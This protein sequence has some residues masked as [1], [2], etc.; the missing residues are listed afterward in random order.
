MAG[1]YSVYPSAGGGGG[2]LS[3]VSFSIGVLDGQAATPQGAS[4]SSNSIFMQS[5]TA[6][7]PGLVSSAAQ[8]FTGVKTFNNGLVSNGSVSMSSN[9]ISNLA[10]PTTAQEAATK[11]YVDTSLSAFQPLEAVALASTINYPGV[12]VANVL[13]ITAT[14]AISIDGSTPNA[15]D[16]VLL[17][18]QT[19]QAQNGVYVVTGVGSVGVSPVLTRAGDYNTAAEVNSGASIPVIS[20]AV[21]KFTIWIQ[22]A[23]VITI[24][25][26]ALVFSQYGAN[27]QNIP[28]SVGAIDGAAA[29]LNGAVIGSS[30]LY[31]QAASAANPGLVSSASQTFAGVKTFNSA[32]NFNSLGASSPLR[33]DGSKNL[34]AGSTSLATE[35]VSSLSLTNQVVGSLLSNPDGIYSIGSSSLA[36]SNSFRFA[37]AAFSQHVF[38]G[39]FPSSAGKP[40]I[41][42]S[43]N[44]G[45]GPNPALMLYSGGSSA[46]QFGTDGAGVFIAN[47]GAGQK[48]FIQADHFFDYKDSATGL[49]Y[50][51]GSIT[52]FTL[53]KVPLMM[54]GST[55]GT[56]AIKA[57][58]NTSVYTLT[59][60]QSTGTASWLLQASNSL[61]STSWIS[62]GQAI[63]SI[64]FTN[65]SVTMTSSTGGSA[66]TVRYP[67]VQSSSTGFLS[68]DGLGNMSWL[69][70]AAAA[71][72]EGTM[73]AFTVNST[74]L[75]KATSSI[76]TVYSYTIVGGGGG[77][78]GTNAGANAVGAGGGAGG[79]ALGTFTGIAPLTA[80][81]IIIG[82]G[83]P[84][85]ATTPANGATGSSSI[86]GSGVG[87]QATG[88]GGGTLGSTSLTT[89]GPVPGGAGGVG[90][91]SF[92]LSI[93]GGAGSPPP[94]GVNAG[95]SGGDTMFGGAGTFGTV[96]AGAGN[97]A[98]GYGAGGG[99]GRVG[100]GG[101][102]GA[103]GVIIITQVTP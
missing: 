80:I 82:A 5:A 23:T 26:D 48:L 9:K 83:G 6:T 25:T 89:F 75:T 40:Y 91:G 79:C 70:P 65:G 78:G 2:G 45:I 90:S 30:T 10:D 71:L 98:N 20:G 99:G 54:S 61:G 94:I 59:L 50:V 11:N 39:T 102:N 96:G 95:G 93:T 35:T 13:T 84:G 72:G 69:S 60:P 7:S 52:A 64:S 57:D 32:P 21:N 43:H 37:Q 38:V 47:T 12:L 33:T 74:F 100:G 68:N 22:T 97:N 66:Y 58:D 18:N 16:R 103:A 51:T 49:S 67:G 56:V 62:P 4:V 17:K 73:T 101:G 19:A 63:G 44:L 86:I 87:L 28:I 41:A 27:P 81:S 8:T 3:S 34:I 77:G 1:N 42:L 36:S 85:G 14:G 31:L 76:L 15:S 24:N 53:N 29:S 92:I 55:S 88:G 46:Y